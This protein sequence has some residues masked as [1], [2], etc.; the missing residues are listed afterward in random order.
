MK[1]IMMAMT[2]ALMLATMSCTRE[3]GV[4]V[5]AK[6]GLMVDTDTLTD[7]VIHFDVP[8]VTQQPM[9][10][11]TL[12]DAQMTDLWL[13][14]FLGDDLIQTIHQSSTDDGF[15]S[16]AVTAETGTH[17][18]CFVSSRGT[19][20]TVTEGEI[21]W[22]KPSDTF[23]QVL[24]LN[25][26]PQTATA[27]SVELQRVVARLR[28]SVTDEVP[29][30]LSKLSIT[31]E[32]WHNGLDALTGDPTAFTPRTA[33]INVPASYVGTTGTLTASI[34]GF[35]SDDYTTDVTV[36]ALDV[37]SQTIASVSLDDVP[38]SRNKTTVYT[39]PLFTRQPTFG[40]STAEAWGDDITGSW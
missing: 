5:T 37:N 31:A 23:W 4:P 11:G 21:V 30:N 20:P 15:G 25:V 34:F 36:S 10:R 33:T 8:Q 3:D 1:K 12:S 35:C 16:M 29:A 7:L 17:H 6:T 9:T 40:L 38:L 26:T 14:D 39:G 2:A 24:T 19:N 22:E 32:T 27:Q 28:I 18:F 13:F